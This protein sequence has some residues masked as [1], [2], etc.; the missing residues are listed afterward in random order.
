MSLWIRQSDV[1]FHGI[2]HV[3]RDLL[4]KT[5]FGLLS[6]LRPESLRFQEEWCRVKAGLS[7]SAGQSGS[8]AHLHPRKANRGRGFL[9]YF[10]CAT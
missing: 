10:W 7:A 8:D 6:M 3:S 5:V 1:W 4:T 9:R 2:P